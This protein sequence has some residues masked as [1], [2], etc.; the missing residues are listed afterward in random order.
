MSGAK[1]YQVF[2]SS[3]FTDLKVERQAV[4]RHILDLKHIPAGMELF[5]AADFD[6]LEYIKKIIDECDYYVLIL[7]GR[8]GSMDPDGVS[9][10]EREYDY[11]VANG[12]VVLAF[13]HDDLGAIASRDVEANHA[14]KLALD[15]FRAKV[16]SGRLVSMWR[17]RQSLELA[18]LKSLMHAFNDVPAVGWIRGDSAASTDLLQQSNQ[19][20]LDNARL[21]AEV[22]QLTAQAKPSVEHLAG[23]DELFEFRYRYQSGI[24][25]NRRS[26]QSS[27]KL[28][29][30]Q[31]FIGLA[32]Q[33]TTSKTEAAISTG[34]VAAAKDAK[35]EHDVYLLDATDRS[36]M[37]YQFEAMGLITLHVSKSTKGDVHEFMS[38]TPN[39]RKVLIEGMVVK[40]TE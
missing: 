15:A 17:D 13:V 1:K 30:R 24:S 25:S 22:A 16:Q 2:V 9:Y 11:A 19:L 18:V 27:M 10:T 26:V 4:I 7:G 35:K 14:A 6:Q 38:L 39:G 12:K 36:R 21:L 29:W 20:L 8:Y 28:T 3:T 37:K 32:M 23:L 33:L 40:A 34:V 31:I 5:P